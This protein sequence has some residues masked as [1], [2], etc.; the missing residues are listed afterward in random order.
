MNVFLRVLMMGLLAVSW[1]TMI[2]T[3]NT[4][5]Q[6][7]LTMFREVVSVDVPSVL[8]VYVKLLSLGSLDEH[9][10]SNLLR[11]AC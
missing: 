2:C 9:R 4:L 6:L 7:F 5:A 1:C 11:L 3:M 8:L 10:H